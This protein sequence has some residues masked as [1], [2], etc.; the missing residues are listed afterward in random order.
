[1]KFVL[2]AIRCST[3]VA[4]VG[5]ANPVTK[6]TELGGD[7]VGKFLRTL[8]GCFGGPLDLLPVLVCPGE[9]VSISAHHALASRNGVA[10]ERRIS[11]P[12]V[13]TCVDVVDRSRDVESLA[14][15]LGRRPSAIC[16]SPNVL[17]ERGFNSRIE[18][19]KSRAFAGER[20]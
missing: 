18:G 2:V 14:H 17:V 1:M 12:D 20:S 11:V 13:G 4:G 9:K 6:R 8:A 16:N 7:F 15:V 3:D 10:G 5:N 19:T